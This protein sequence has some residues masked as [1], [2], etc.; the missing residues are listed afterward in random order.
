ML[1]GVLVNTVAILLGTFVGAGD[2]ESESP[3]SDLEGHHIRVWNSG[4]QA[5]AFASSNSSSPTS[6]Q[7]AAEEFFF[8]DICEMPTNIPVLWNMDF[9]HGENN[10]TLPLGAVVVV[11][12]TE[13]SVRIATADESADFEM[14]SK[15]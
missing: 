15:Y 10:A 6:R 5:K 1:V 12:A 9:G 3:L 2:D 7:K 4:L 11:D 13:G 14:R 8:R